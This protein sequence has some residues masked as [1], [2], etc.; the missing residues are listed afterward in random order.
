MV[1]LKNRE[2]FDLF[3]SR[4]AKHGFTVYEQAWR[5]WYYIL[6]F[7]EDSIVHFKVKQCKGWLFSIW[8]TR[9]DDNGEFKMFDLFAQPLNNID[10]FKPSA[11]ALLYT[12]TPSDIL[13]T[14]RLDFAFSNAC[15]E[16]LAPIRY[17]KYMAWYIH[18]TSGYPRSRWQAKLE[19][20]KHAGQ[21]MY[22]NFI[23]NVGISDKERGVTT[24]RGRKQYPFRCVIL[25]FRYLFNKKYKPS[26]RRL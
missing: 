13:S 24:Y 16:V 8:F 1:E 26:W 25:F 2:M 6:D 12:S 14:T 22:N 23:G 18:S 21:A 5:S 9:S 19:R 20:F 3:V 4:A 10:K 7:G 15:H 11:S 17:D